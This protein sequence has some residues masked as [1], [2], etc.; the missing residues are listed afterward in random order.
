MEA[1]NPIV[2]GLMVAM[3]GG[4]LA[5]GGWYAR[6]LWRKREG[7][8]PK[9]RPY[10]VVPALPISLDLDAPH[11]PANELYLMDAGPTRIAVI[12]VIRTINPEM[13]LR[14]AKILTEQ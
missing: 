4:A 7:R 6:D 1:G 2:W 13:G 5:A 12:A 3:V 8:A 9:R 10:S 11:P 14:D